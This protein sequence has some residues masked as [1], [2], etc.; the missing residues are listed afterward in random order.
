MT[1][2]REHD[3]FRLY[4]KTGLEKHLTIHYQ[5]LPGGMLTLTWQK[6]VA[7]PAWFFTTHSYWPPCFSRTPRMSRRATPRVSDCMKSGVSATI[8]PLRR[9]NTEGAGK[10]VTVQVSVTF[11]PRS[12]VTSCKGVVKVGA[13]FV[14]ATSRRIHCPD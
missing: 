6:H 14:S 1:V 2:F 5:Q 9:Q 10:P 11:L 12:A 4:N 7:S 3:A 8:S 13:L